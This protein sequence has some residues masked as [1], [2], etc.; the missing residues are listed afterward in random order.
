MLQ[1]L[2]SASTRVD[3][4]TIPSSK[5]GLKVAGRK[6]RNPSLTVM[7]KQEQFRMVISLISH[8]IPKPINAYHFFLTKINNVILGV[9]AQCSDI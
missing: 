6:L 2:E 7:N 3:I 8:K 9:L 1:S 5:N 4:E